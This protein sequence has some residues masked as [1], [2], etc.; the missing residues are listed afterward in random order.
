MAEVLEVPKQG[1]LLS[2]SLVSETT[3]GGT[4]Q[5]L[6]PGAEVSSVV[7]FHHIYEMCS[8]FAVDIGETVGTPPV[9]SQFGKF[10]GS[11]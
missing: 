8:E 5:E 11:E 2:H 7:G 6:V 9:D 1:I 10:G 3:Y 4:L